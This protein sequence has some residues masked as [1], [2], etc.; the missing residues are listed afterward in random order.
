MMLTTVLFTNE[1]FILRIYVETTEQKSEN[2]KFI[3]YF[4]KFNNLRM[5]HR[6]G[7]IKISQVSESKLEV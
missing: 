7:Q 5:K 4:Y 3:I 1:R 2:S 6:Q